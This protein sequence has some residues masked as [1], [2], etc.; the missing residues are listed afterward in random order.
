[1]ENRDSTSASAEELAEFESVL[2]SSLLRRSPSVLRVAQYIAQTYREGGSEEIKEYNIAVDALGKAADFDPKRDSI[3]RVEVH[4][5]RKKIDLFYRTEGADHKLKLIIDPGKYIPRF[6]QVLPAAVKPVLDVVEMAVAVEAA[7]SEQAA[8]LSPSKFSR[9]ALLAPVTALLA[10]VAWSRMS[11]PAASTPEAVFLLAGTPANAVIVAAAG[12]VMHGDRWFQGGAS[13]FPAPPLPMIPSG[14]RTGLRL[15]DFDYDIPLA[16]V[17]WE[18]RLF[19]GPRNGD[20]EE[21]DPIARGFDVRANGVHLIDAQD[22]DLGS[23]GKSQRSIVRVFRDIKPAPDHV[24]H[25]QFRS[26]RESAYVSAIGLSPGKAGSLLPI[27]MISKS[28]P[29][30]DADGNTWSPDEEFV[31]G[32]QLKLCHKIESGGLDRNMIAGERYGNFSYNIPVSKGTYRLKL[33]FT[34]SWFGPGRD[35]GGG[36]GSRRFDVYAEKQSLLL[37]FDLFRESRNRPVVKEFHGLKTDADG[38][39]NLRFVERANHAAVNALELTE[40]PG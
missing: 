18:L 10:F 36:I 7:Q 3:V 25:L 11:F 26:G 5:L 27:R 33:Y 28:A 37:D 31:S 21:Q 14:S 19:F 22:S 13:V 1:M 15:E 38:Y 40:E 20:E 17:P 32:G 35:G 16:D 6:V 24:L 4:R 30:T 34:E 9:W 12:F 23:G 8:N 29:W 2:Q 39:I